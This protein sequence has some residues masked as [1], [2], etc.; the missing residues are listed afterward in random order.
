MSYDKNS[1][2]VKLYAGMPIIA[3]K[4]NEH[5][6]LKKLDKKTNVMIIQDEDKCQE[7]PFDKFQQM[8]YVSFCITIHMPH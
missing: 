4:N 1:Q 3:R 2:D 8:F 7:I 6:Q 5:L